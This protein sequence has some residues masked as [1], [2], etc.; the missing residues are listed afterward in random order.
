MTQASPELKQQ[1]AELVPFPIATANEDLSELP[2]LKAR[3]AWHQEKLTYFTRQSRLRPD[4]PAS[5]IAC[6]RAIQR[7]R[8]LT[9]SINQIKA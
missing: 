8:V 5:R 1:L 6:R 9:Q 3:L 7:I 2:F 4:D